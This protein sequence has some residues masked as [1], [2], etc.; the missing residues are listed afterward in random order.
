MKAVIFWVLSIFTLFFWAMGGVDMFMT[1]TG[2]ENYLKDYPPEMVSWLQN[3]PLLR[4][5]VWALTSLL[6]T[7][8]GMMLI[9]RRSLAPL[10]LWMAS[11]L[12]IISFLGYD[13]LLANGAHYY[14][15][16][17]M[18]SNSVMIA[19]TLLLAWYADAAIKARTFRR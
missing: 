1:L 6:G 4:K 15:L 16:A 12:M 14:G 10:F 19:V 18:I 3:F 13:L 5:V 11:G 8:G 2:N 9:L 7:V 17:G